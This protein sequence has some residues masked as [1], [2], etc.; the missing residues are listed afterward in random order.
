MKSERLNFVIELLTTQMNHW[1]LFPIV[2]TASGIA[3]LLT[4]IGD[5]GNPDFLL[6]TICGLFPVLFFLIRYFAERAWLFFLCHG[7]VMACALILPVSSGVMD[8]VICGVCAA[9]YL[10][11]SL[12]LRLR[13]NAAVYSAPIHPIAALALSVAADFMLHKQDNAPDWDRYYI[14]T[15]IGVLACYVIIFYLRQ[16]L[17]FLQVNRSS[18]GYLPAKELLRSGMGFVLSFTLG[19]VAVLLLSL[20]AK[21]LEPLLRA[22]QKVIVAF[23]RF[24][25]GHSGDESTEE[26][27]QSA[28]N[29]GAVTDPAAMGLPTGG[30]FWLWEVLEYVAIVLFAIG[31]V[32]VLVRAL[33][34][35]VKLIQ[36]RFGEKGKAAAFSPEEE[37]VHDVRENVFNGIS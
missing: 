9:S 20:N 36:Q 31:V 29:T 26:L 19:G 23:L 8:R 33:F 16:Y 11:H 27:I 32:F 7:A 14:F 15:L 4:G 28:E 3:R 12:T 2:M 37:A 1:L 30:T 17:K 25:F 34:F 35:L 10:I 13:E 24:L 21:W 18:A 6:W 22:L 5:A